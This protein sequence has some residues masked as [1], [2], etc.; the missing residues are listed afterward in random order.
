MA[1][2]DE[3]GLISAGIV[4]GGAGGSG[5]L[6][7]LQNSKKIRVVFVV[8][9]NPQAPGLAM[10]RPRAPDLA[11]FKKIRAKI[12]TLRYK[13]GGLAQQLRTRR[14]PGSPGSAL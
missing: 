7:F 3:A 2:M 4:G 12:H 9:Q 1:S 11:A 8:D 5:L 6:A 13:I 14:T 10:A